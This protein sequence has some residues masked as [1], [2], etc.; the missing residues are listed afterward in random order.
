MKKTVIIILFFGLIYMALR[1]ISGNS[2]SKSEPEEIERIEKSIGQKQQ[3]QSSG[4]EGNGRVI[5]KKINPHI[6]ANG[7]L[8]KEEEQD[9]INSEIKHAEFRLVATEMVVCNSD[10]K[11]DCL[12]MINPADTYNSNICI[13]MRELCVGSKTEAYPANETELLKVWTPERVISYLI[14]REKSKNY[15]LDPVENGSDM[16]DQKWYESKLYSLM[17]QISK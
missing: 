14:E 4:T 6:N 15:I 9:F 2:V 16:Y 8:S 5:Y 3:T 10:Q 1:N 12:E 13:T 11:V 17:N 7:D